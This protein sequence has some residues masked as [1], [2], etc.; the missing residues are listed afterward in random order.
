MENHL[1]YIQLHTGVPEKAKGFYSKL[2]NWKIGDSVGP[3]Q[4][5]EVAFGGV[6]NG[7]MMKAQFLDIPAHWIPFITVDKISDY[8]EKA[9]VLGARVV[10]EPETVP[11]KGTYSLLLDPTGAPLAL[12]EPKS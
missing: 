6:V 8:V 1:A 9:K 11:G 2:F 10:Q 3:G 12:W 5:M 4:Y 7:G